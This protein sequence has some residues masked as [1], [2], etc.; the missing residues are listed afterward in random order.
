MLGL[1]GDWFEIYSKPIRGPVLDGK[2]GSEEEEGDES[3]GGEECPPP[4]SRRFGMGYEGERDGL[5]IVFITKE[6]VF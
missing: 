2:V 3:G 5:E 4:L 6:G 1:E